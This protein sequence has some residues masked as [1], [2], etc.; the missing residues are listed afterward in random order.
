LHE[1]ARF[2]YWKRD[3]SLEAP[4]AARKL[5]KC[6]F[7]RIET[8]PHRRRMARIRFNPGERWTSWLSRAMLTIGR[9]SDEV[10]IGDKTLVKGDQ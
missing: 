5:G 2:S 6:F 8:G 1:R 9:Y 3:Q 4:T 7:Q 10:D